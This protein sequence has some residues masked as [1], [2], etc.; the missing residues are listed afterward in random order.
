MVANSK[1]QLLSLNQLIFTTYSIY[2]G[3]AASAYCLILL[4]KN[5]IL[6]AVLKK[7]A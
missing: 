6:R 3:V 5:L 2:L 7:K 1:A 4:L